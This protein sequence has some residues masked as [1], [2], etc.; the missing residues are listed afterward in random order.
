M[1]SIIRIE[2]IE[3]RKT[4]QGKIFYRT[5]ALLDDGTT[6]YGYGKDFDLEDRVEVFHDPK[7]DVIK[8]RKPKYRVDN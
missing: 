6:A 7:W 4:R 8:M 3:E 2:H 1:R 5:H